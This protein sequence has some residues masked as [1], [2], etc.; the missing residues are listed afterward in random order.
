MIDDYL[1]SHDF[2]DSTRDRYGRILARFFEEVED[3]GGIDAGDL[4]SWVRSNPWGSSSRSVAVSI[5]KGF[6]SWRYG[7][8]HPALSA[9]VKAGRSK[10]QRSLDLDQVSD[11]LSIFDTSSP[12]GRRD[13]AMASLFLDTGLR[14]SEVAR[15]D[16]RDLDLDRCRLQ[17]IVK[18]GDWGDAVFSEITSNYLAAWIAD[19]DLITPIKIRAVFVSTH[20]NRGN[21]MKRA[22]IGRLVRD[23]GKS[24]GIE[25]SPHDFRRTFATISTRAGAPSRILQK[26][27]RW[28]SPSMVDRYTR[29]ITQDDFRNYFPVK[30]VMGDY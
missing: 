5:V 3:P 6:L 7:S 17:V 14:V 26:A 13:L 9:R 19:R 23:W 22:S 16:I 12:K 2:A 11:L 15:L 29:A 25:L 28:R 21:P 8:G 1:D 18:G 4:L 27:G 30:V 24:I 20:R 10:R